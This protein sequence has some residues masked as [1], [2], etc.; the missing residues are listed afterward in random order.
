MSERKTSISIPP[1]I[2]A[3]RTDTSKLLAAST[4]FLYYYDDKFGFIHAS[5]IE[6]LRE[7]YE[8]FKKTLK[9]PCVFIVSSSPPIKDS[10]FHKLWTEAH[11][12][13]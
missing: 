13:E 12:D 6:K 7:A 2:S 1:I 4:E 8:R 3:T 11:P 5:E 9:K 10:F